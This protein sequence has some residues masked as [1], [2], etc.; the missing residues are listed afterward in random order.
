VLVISVLAGCG[1][2]SYTAQA[3][4]ICKKYTKQTSAFAKPTNIADL[5]VLTDKTLP[6]LDKA[7]N[8]L[9]ALQPPPEK[10][11]AGQRESQRPG[12]PSRIQGLQQELEA[13]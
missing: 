5:A 12:N 11:A 13:F 6:L 8:E 4:A 9:G 2:K 7:A 1:G 10:R 3:D